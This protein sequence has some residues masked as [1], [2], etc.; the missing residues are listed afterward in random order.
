[1]KPQHKK[2]FFEI[3]KQRH[4]SLGGEEADLIIEA[5]NAIEALPV[6]RLS[7]DEI[8]HIGTRTITRKIIDDPYG[9]ARAIEEA[10][11]AAQ[12]RPV[13]QKMTA[14]IWQHRVSAEI[15]AS[16]YATASDGWTLIDT[17]ER[18]YP[19]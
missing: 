16:I 1:M 11:I 14:Y 19:V 9:Y 7:V 17:I 3:V 4:C 6:V 8:T 13:V 15:V 18:E 12:D 5:I 10:H 2:I